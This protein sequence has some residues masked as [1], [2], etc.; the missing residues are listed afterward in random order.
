MQV[1]RP[2]AFGIGVLTALVLGSGT[3]YAATGGKFILGHANTATKVT[4]LTNHH[5]TALSLTSRS[6]TP[7]LK[8]SSS[9]KVTRLNADRLDGRDSTAFAL[10]SGQ[11]NTITRTGVPIDVDDDGYA[12][13]LVALATCPAGTRL[14]GG[15]GDDYTSDGTL[16]I[17]SPLNR[18]TWMVASTSSDVS[19]GN[20]ENLVAYA[21]CYNPRGSVHGGSY[22]I[23]P[24]AVAPRV[25]GLG[26]AKDRLAR[27]LG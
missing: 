27:K 8:V 12:D 9:S 13:D 15:G 2:A 17:D 22:R 20:G 21:Q 25:D 26:L 19:A 1:S 6:G 23:A 7:S 14:T 16:F 4:K 24:R 11:T 10:A 5:G 18:T 3:A